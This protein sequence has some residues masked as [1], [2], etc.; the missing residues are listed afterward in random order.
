[1]PEV[2]QVNAKVVADSVSE[3]G[4]RLTT[5]VVTLPRSALAELNTHRAFSR[6]SASLAPFHARQIR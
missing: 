5:M 6:N 4:D 2:T 3:A 1:M